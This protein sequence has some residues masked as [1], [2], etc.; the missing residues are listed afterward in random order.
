VL[1]FILQIQQTTMIIRKTIQFIKI[2]NYRQK[3]SIAT[4]V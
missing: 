1:G 3:T 4:K 2:G